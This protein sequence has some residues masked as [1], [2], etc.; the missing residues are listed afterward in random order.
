MKSSTTRMC[1]VFTWARNFDFNLAATTSLQ[2]IFRARQA[3]YI[4]FGLG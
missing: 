2:P 3:V 4:S 1:V